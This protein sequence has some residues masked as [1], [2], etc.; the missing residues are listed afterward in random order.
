MAKLVLKGDNS[1]ISKMYEHLRQEHPSVKG[2][3]SMS[4]TGEK[5]ILDLDL[6]SIKKEKIKK[7]IKGECL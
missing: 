6:D 7:M 5:N 4:R 1:Y 3:I 2:R